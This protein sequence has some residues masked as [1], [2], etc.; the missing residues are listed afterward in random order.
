MDSFF[1]VGGAG[2]FGNIVNFSWAVAQWNQV[3][4]VVDLDTTPPLAEYWIGTSPP[5][6][7]VATGIGRMA[8]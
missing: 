8:E 7:Q 6:T 4:V 3:I 2:G 1:D 5:L